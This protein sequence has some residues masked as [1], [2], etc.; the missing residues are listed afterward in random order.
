MIIVAP[1]ARPVKKTHKEAYYLSG[2][3]AHR[4]QGLLADI[5]PHND[6]VNGVVE[7]LEKK[8]PIELERNN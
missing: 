5:V 6:G 2:G 4:G 3:A 7:L 1:A 8:Y